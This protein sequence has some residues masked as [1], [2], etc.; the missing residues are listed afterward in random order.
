MKFK[1]QVLYVKVPMEIHNVIWSIAT[2]AA[3]L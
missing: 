3:F 1:G 2:A